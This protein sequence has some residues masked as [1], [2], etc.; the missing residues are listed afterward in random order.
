LIT[1]DDS[2]LPVVPTTQSHV[3]AAIRAA[4]EEN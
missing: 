2:P 4:L 3:A 1:A